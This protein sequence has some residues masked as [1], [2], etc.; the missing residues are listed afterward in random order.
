MKRNT[1]IY[2]IIAASVILAGIILCLVGSAVGNARNEQIFP[3]NT[4]NGRRYTYY[5]GDSDIGRVKFDAVKAQVN[6]IGGAEK[7]YI[8]VINFNE[9]LC[10]F[11]NSNAMVTFRESPDVSSVLRFWE[12]GFTFKGLRYLL[13][14][15]GDENGGIINVYMAQDVK[16]KAF[17][18]TVES[19]KISV[20]NISDP[21]DYS[22]VVGSGGISMTDVNTVSNIAL[23]ARDASA[24]AI[25][26]E[27]ITA[28]SLTVKAQ[29]ADLK[30]KG[31]VT[32][33]CDVAIRTGSTAI[34]YK[35]LAENPVFTAEVNS[36]GKLVIDGCDDYIDVY[37]YQ[38]E[39]TEPGDITSFVRVTG[40]DL[41][42]NLDTPLPDTPE[43]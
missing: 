14:S 2:F 27:N 28:Q 17:D 13:R 38:P 4:E 7:S 30:V 3:E 20:K 19:G 5:F 39:D 22:L 11:S 25:S 40:A 8:E 6:I 34:E 41:S 29:I 32:D 42:V 9:N 31:L 37:K 10:T 18:I 1:R 24:A 12:N 43:S 36:A 33:A 23:T 21:T 26:L 16:V 15:G 35:P